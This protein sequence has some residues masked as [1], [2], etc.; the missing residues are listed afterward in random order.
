VI[1]PASRRVLERCGFTHRGSGLKA[2]PARGGVFPV[3]EF[4]LDRRTWE[5]LKS[6]SSTGYVPNPERVMAAAL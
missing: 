4:R 6:W 1:N 3:D 2:F 5:S